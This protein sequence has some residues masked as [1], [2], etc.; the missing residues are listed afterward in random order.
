MHLF[1]VEP[2]GKI[3][4][5][6]AKK[7]DFENWQEISYIP[8]IPYFFYRVNG[9][10]NFGYR[11]VI[12][13]NVKPWILKYSN[14][15]G[16][17]YFEEIT[18]EGLIHFKGYPCSSV[19]GIQGTCLCLGDIVAYLIFLGLRHGKTG[20]VESSVWSPKEIEKMKFKILDFLLE[21]ANQKDK[22]LSKN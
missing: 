21:E 16:E 18:R 22:A 17:D 14:G 5:R 4:K 9:D 19:L 20:L 8:D 1:L 7:Y 2:K 6:V 12:V 10:V 13:G 15:D 3:F 11:N